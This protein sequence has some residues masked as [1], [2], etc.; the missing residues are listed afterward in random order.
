MEE[1]DELARSFELG[2][3]VQRDRL[4]GILKAHRGADA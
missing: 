2:R 3:C 4:N 1:L